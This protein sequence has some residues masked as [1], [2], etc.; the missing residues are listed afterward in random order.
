MKVSICIPQYNRIGYLLK[1]LQRIEKQTYGNIEI[2]VSD[3]CSTDD[4]ENRIKELQ[5]I[6]RFPLV[7]KRNE[8][9]LGYDRNYRQSIEL[10][11]GDYCFILGNDDT[12]N[13]AD[14]IQYLVDFL[15]GT[16]YPD[17]GFCNYFEE[18]D[19]GHI[20]RRAST[21]GILG[22]GY[23]VAMKNYSCFSFV[24]G[25]IY[26]KATFIQYNTA[27]YDGSVFAQMYLGCLMLAK[28]CSLFSIETPL[29]IKDILINNQR[30]NNYRDTLAREWKDYKEVDAGLPS[31]M[32]VLISAFRDAG[33]LNQSII[34]NIHKKIYALTYTHWL[35]DYRSNGAY[36][37]ALGLSRGM[38]PSS[39]P[40][41]AFLS[42]W[43]KR[44]IGLLYRFSTLVGLTTPVYLFNKLK[45]KLYGL[46][47]RK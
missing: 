1:S 18:Q 27:A 32:N 25:L 2:V 3:D 20:Y 46:I 34:Y 42:P 31:V 15:Q 41:Y 33:V 22:T 30:P 43:N 11:S 17:I 40:T 16:G 21:T 26:K 37:A 24:A 12:L 6:Y 38:K 29:V 35:L 9:N 36:P 19:P 5:A 10:A 14:T 23:G 13:E 28:G 8:N 4:T 45:V 39:L 47:K 44:R 7:Y